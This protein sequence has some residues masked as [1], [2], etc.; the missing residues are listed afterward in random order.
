[1]DAPDAGKTIPDKPPAIAL[2]LP[3]VTIAFNAFN[4][5]RHLSPGVGGVDSMDWIGLHK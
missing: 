2:E 1:M 3:G 4:G 5:V